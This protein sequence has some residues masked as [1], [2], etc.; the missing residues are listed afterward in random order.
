[1]KL[2]KSDPFRK[3]KIMGLIFVTPLLVGFLVFSAYPL[4]SSIYLSF[5]DYNIYTKP[6][7]IGFQNYIN[8]LNDARFW[9]IMKNTVLYVAGN[10]PLQVVLSLL[11]ANLL[12]K[13]LRGITIFRTAFYIPVITSWVAAGVTLRW[14]L[15]SEVG[16]LNTLLWS[17]FHVKGPAWLMDPRWAMISVIMA[18]VWK[19]VGFNTMLYL[20]GL[21]D[22]PEEINDAALVDGTTKIQ[23]FFYITIPLLRPT[24]F[25]VSA[26]AIINS[27]Q[28]FDNVYVMTGGGPMD[29][30]RVIVYH[31]YQVG[32]LFLRMGEASAIAWV[33]FV[34]IFS[35]SYF[36]WRQSG[37]GYYA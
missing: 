31:L 17:I 10:V 22:I 5:T 9:K 13:K 7:F 34:I 11:L 6:N 20:A 35:I 24:T 33:L 27:F 37:G 1:M 36:R 18:N 32:F 21:Q 25:F 2:N 29:A 26:M 8:L 16:L 3:E 14:I 15:A 19:G 28:V 30:T 4:V 12:N 23:R